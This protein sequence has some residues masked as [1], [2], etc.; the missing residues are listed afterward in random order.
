MVTL[1]YQ[2]FNV[3]SADQVELNLVLKNKYI[4]KV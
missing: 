1:Y 4:K 2:R 3:K